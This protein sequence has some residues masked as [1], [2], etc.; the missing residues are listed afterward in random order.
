MGVCTRCTTAF[1]A[2]YCANHPNGQPCPRSACGGVVLTDCATAYQHDTAA[3]SQPV[4]S[5]GCCDSE[6]GK[7]AEWVALSEA[8]AI[9]LGLL[10]DDAERWRALKE[11][12]AAHVAKALALETQ[13]VS[14]LVR[15]LFTLIYSAVAK[16]ATTEAERVAIL[17]HAPAQTCPLL[18]GGYDEI[19]A[20][21]LSG[22]RPHPRLRTASL[23]MCAVVSQTQSPSLSSPPD[24]VVMSV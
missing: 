18:L 7:S 3:P 5:N 8:F 2:H 13:R 11:D 16:C 1:S 4:C 21:G 20:A 14:F 9:A 23:P 15:G 22:A 24:G 17:R 10:W 19:E 6:S 12:L